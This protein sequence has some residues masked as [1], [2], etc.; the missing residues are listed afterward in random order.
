MSSVVV[1]FDGLD[2]VDD[3]LDGKVGEEDEE[4]ECAESRR[5]RLSA[6]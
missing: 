5:D 1:L 4:L 3:D 2:G 6:L